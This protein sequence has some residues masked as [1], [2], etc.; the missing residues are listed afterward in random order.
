MHKK[1]VMPWTRHEVFQLSFGIFHLTMNMI[2]AILN[3]HHGTIN[4]SGSLSQLFVVLE[5]VWLN[6]EHLDFHML[7]A[8]LTQILDSLIL[9]AWCEECGFPSLDKFAKLKPTPADLLELARKI[10]MKHATPTMTM[11][12]VHTPPK[13]EMPA[14]GD[15]SESA[16]ESASGPPPAPL[17]SSPEDII[18][19]NIVRLM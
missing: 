15:E 16:N 1:D 14:P 19:E 17:T 12:P 13:S 5:K 2:W 4:Q 18:H 8:V 9:N 7:L 3:T 11:K 10:V 6:A